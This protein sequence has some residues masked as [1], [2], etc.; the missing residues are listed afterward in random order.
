MKH[1][2]VK[3]INNN[4]NEI[5]ILAMKSIYTHRNELLINETKCCEGIQYNLNI[6]IQIT[7]IFTCE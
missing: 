6:H 4:R 1:N 2:T 7:N 5:V 3:E